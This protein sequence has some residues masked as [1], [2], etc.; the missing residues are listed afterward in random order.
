MLFQIKVCVNVFY[1]DRIFTTPLMVS[2]S[3]SKQRKY[4]ARL[5]A[6]EEE[7]SRDRDKVVDGRNE[8]RL[9]YNILRDEVR[10]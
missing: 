4:E 10:K 2:V 7:H 6:L 3:L 1:S 8:L 5:K 9:V